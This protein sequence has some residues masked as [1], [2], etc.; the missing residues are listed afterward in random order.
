MLVRHVLRR[1]SEYNDDE[2]SVSDKLRVEAHLRE[3]AK[4][5]KALD[6]I[7]FGA[8]LASTLSI[9]AVPNLSL[10]QIDAALPILPDR[11]FF[12]RVAL[13]GICVAFVLVVVWYRIHLPMTSWEVAGVPGK[14]SLYPG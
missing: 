8:R 13:A 14:S 2:L 12:S 10:N 9:T 6:D 1:L 4:C 11:R 3:C 7:R 5:R